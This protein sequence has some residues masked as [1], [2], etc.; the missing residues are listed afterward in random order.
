MHAA[1]HWF[2]DKMLLSILY[3]PLHLQTWTLFYAK[4]SF[5]TIKSVQFVRDFRKCF[6]FY[7]E[8]QINSH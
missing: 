2:F 6:F 3:E 8:A 7:N 1:T 5:S 4:G